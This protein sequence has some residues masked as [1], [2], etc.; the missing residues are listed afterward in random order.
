MSD[1]ENGLNSGHRIE[2]LIKEDLS[3][4]QISPNPFTQ[5]F[6]ISFKNLPLPKTQI[7]I[8]NL[9]GQLV[10]T[11]QVNSFKGDSNI[12]IDMSECKPG[13]YFANVITGSEK[14]VQKLIKL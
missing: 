3:N 6:T 8:F 12:K 11:V 14:F 5:T 9:M 10:K 4:I 2:G 1:V 7:Q 13:V